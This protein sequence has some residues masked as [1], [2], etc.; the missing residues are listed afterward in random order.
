MITLR[1]VDAANFNEVINLKRESFQYVGGPEH[2]LAEA[3][4]YR[5]DS[6]AYAICSDGAPVGLVILR[7]RPEEGYPYSF[8]GIFIADDQQRKGFG[9]AAVEAVMEKFRQERLRGEV[10]IQVHCQN[11]PALKIYRSCGF[12]EI[13][14]AQWNADFLVMRAKL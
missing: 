14:R 5:S 6:T 2:V 4:I 9:R 7:D 1:E 13:R 12:E 11:G 3:Y 10:E 8:T